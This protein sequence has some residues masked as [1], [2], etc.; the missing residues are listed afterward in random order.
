MTIEAFCEHPASNLTAPDGEEGKAMV[1]TCSF[2]KS[3]EVF[4]FGK[5]TTQQKL[6][7]SEN[8]W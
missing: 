7:F 8:H 2:L 6:I 3:R 4:F 5:R 1:G